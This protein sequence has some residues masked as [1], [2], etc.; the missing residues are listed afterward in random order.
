[1]MSNANASIN[2]I[3][4]VYCHILNYNHNNS[5]GRYRCVI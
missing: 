1:M 3:M 4:P 5:E 2:L